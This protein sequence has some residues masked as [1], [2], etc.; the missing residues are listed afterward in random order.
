[1]G[2]KKSYGLSQRKKEAIGSRSGHR[3]IRAR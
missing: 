2:W 3:S 1:M